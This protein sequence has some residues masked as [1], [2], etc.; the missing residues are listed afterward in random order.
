MKKNKAFNL[1]M[2][3][4]DYEHLQILASNENMKPSE[5]IRTLIQIMYITNI[6]TKKRKL[7][8]GGY[9]I[10]FPFVFLNSFYNKLKNNFIKCDFDK[11]KSKIIINGHRNYV[12]K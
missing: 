7:N 5:Y 3:D 12:P 10:T 9:G 11:L 1:C 6:Y 4:N 8:I 2:S